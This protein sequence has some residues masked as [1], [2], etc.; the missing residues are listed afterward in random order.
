M[1]TYFRPLTQTGYLRPKDSLTVAGGWCWFD[2]VERLTRNDAPQII[3]ASEVPDDALTAICQS[4]PPIAGLTMQKPRLMGILNVTP[5]SFSDGGKYDQVDAAVAHGLNMAE[6]GADIVDIGGESTRPGAELVPVAQEVARTQPVISAIRDR[7]AVP[8]SIDTR[9]AQVARCAV[10]AGATMVNDVSGLNFDM[11]LSD[12]VV[13]NDLPMCIMHARGDPKSMQ[14]DPVYENVLLDVCDTLAERIRYA[15]SCGISKDR[16]IID[17][18]IGFGK[19]AEHNLALIRGIAVF[20]GLGCPILL[21]ASRKRFIGGIAGDVQT[22]GRM[23]G[24]V[25]LALFAMTQGVQIVRVHDIAET[26]QALTMW[27]ATTEIGQQP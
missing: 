13:K 14:D 3:P 19:T 25:G 2:H 21:G 23:A 6:S 17:P 26:R 20:H 1:N 24:S 22:S 10:Q 8:I 9:K 11:E 4:R 27:Q 18:G 7:S 12:I 15:Q 5:D 16:L